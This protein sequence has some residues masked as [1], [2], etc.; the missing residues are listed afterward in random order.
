MHRRLHYNQG[1]FDLSS[2]QTIQ[3]E[4][5]QLEHKEEKA[6]A[7]ALY[8]WAMHCK[9]K[10]RTRDMLHY[11][12]KTLDELDMAKVKEREEKE[13]REESKRVEREK[14]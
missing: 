4:D 8:L 11:S 1:G 10:T 3:R 12:F 5:E 6:L 9:L 2:F 14:L 7:K 13:E